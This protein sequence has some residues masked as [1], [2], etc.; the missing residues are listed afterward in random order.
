[1]TRCQSYSLSSTAEPQIEGHLKR[2]AGSS[3]ES[4]QAAAAEV[5]GAEKALLPA[6]HS[7]MLKLLWSFTLNFELMQGLYYS[8]RSQVKRFSY[9]NV[10]RVPNKVRPKALLGAVYAACRTVLRITLRGFWAY[11]P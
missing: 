2:A 6:Q 10:T 5:F 4:A 9:K 11:C 7:D 3:S 1:M 8:L